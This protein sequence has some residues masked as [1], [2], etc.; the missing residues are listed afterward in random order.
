MNEMR[1]MM[2][3]SL[4]NKEDIDERLKVTV[5]A[6]DTKIIWDSE[7]SDEVDAA[8]ATFDKLLKKGYKA[9]KV[10]KDGEAG[11]KVSS[12]DESA[13]KVILVAPMAG[14]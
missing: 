11:D 14:G 2:T 1:V 7:K 8:K 5:E 12:F 9:F 13:E 6:G 4:K 3:Y 10:R